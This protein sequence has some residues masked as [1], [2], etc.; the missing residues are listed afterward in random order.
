MKLSN[1]DSHKDEGVVNYLCLQVPWCGGRRVCSSTVLARAVRK[2]A[3]RKQLELRWILSDEA[4]GKGRD[5]LKT[6]DAVNMVCAGN[7]AHRVA[8]QLEGK[9][10]N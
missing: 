6:L 5:V 9:W 3:S 2:K 10:G 1:W 4:T 7:R 8:E